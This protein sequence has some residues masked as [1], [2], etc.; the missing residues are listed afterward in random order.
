M[1]YTYTSGI[2]ITLFLVLIL[3]SK[4]QKSSAD[5]TLTTW[6][7]VTGVHIALFYLFFTGNIFNF[8]HLLGLEAPLPLFQGPFLLLYTTALTKQSLSKSIKILHSSIPML[9]YLLFLPFLF[10]PSEHKI[11]VYQNNGLGYETLTGCT[12]WAIRLSGVFYVV[13]SYR[14][15]QK[16]RSTLQGQYAYAEKINLSWL[17][18]LISGIAGIW[19]IVFFGTDTLIYFSAVLYVCFIGYFGIRQMGIFTNEV[20]TQILS[21]PQI[22]QEEIAIKYEKTRL[23][24]DTAQNMHK[25]LATAMEMEKL[26]TN[27]ELTL[28]ELARHLGVHANN[29]SQVINSFEQV[30]FYDYINAK[31]VEEFKRVAL[32]PKSQQFTLLSIAYDCGFNS[33]TSFNRNFKKATGL[34]PSEYVQQQQIALK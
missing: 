20:P 5:I 4:K 21:G 32:L 8:P 26:F 33:K 18:Y 11:W 22:S 24:D 7:L 31:R 17:R 1:E 12:N 3:I 10:M 23:S 16:Y 28:A 30:N 2:A 6:L 25:A 27:A 19:L 14:V 29:L 34:S 9:W 15:L 13:I